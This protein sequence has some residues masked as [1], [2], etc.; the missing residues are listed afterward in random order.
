MKLAHEFE[1]AALPIGR[2][3]IQERNVPDEKRTVRAIKAGGVAGGEKYL[4]HG[5]FF[6]VLLVIH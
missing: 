2:A 4:H 5:I 3:I 1:A 6:K